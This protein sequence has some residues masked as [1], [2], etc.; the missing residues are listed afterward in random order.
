MYKNS[1]SF[2]H[3]LQ[4][5]EETKEI[6]AASGL[7]DAERVARGVID[8]MQVMDS[9]SLSQLSYHYVNRMKRS[10]PFFKTHLLAYR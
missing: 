1:I 2:F 9:L 3:S 6:A 4:R 8:D 5:P 7:F 10:Q